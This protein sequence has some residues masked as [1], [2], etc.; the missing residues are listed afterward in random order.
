MGSEHVIRRGQ[1]G[2]WNERVRKTEDIYFSIGSNLG[3]RR[4]N[5]LSAIRSLDSVFGIHHAKLSSLVETVP[6]GFFSARNFL[7]CAVL[8]KLPLPSEVEAFESACLE[9]LD[10][11]KRI[12]ADMGRDEQMEITPNG[13]R[14]YKDRI[15]DIDILFCGSAHIRNSRLTIPHP[16][17][18]NREFVILPLQEIAE[19]S[20]YVMFPEVFKS[21]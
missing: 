7:N 21:K 17:I 9:I 20:L 6:W 10:K 19:P 5:I 18:A 11:C 13:D 12:E 1:G 3:D 4:K 2:T 14:V 15:I 16:L 8:Y